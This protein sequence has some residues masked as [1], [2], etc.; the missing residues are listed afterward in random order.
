LGGLGL[1][2][3]YQSSGITELLHDMTYRRPREL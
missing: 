1:G 3:E 2:N